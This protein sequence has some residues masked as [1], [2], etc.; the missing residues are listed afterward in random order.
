MHMLNST[1]C[2]RKYNYDYSDNNIDK[3]DELRD[4]WG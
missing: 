2:Q 1:H 3:K 4:M